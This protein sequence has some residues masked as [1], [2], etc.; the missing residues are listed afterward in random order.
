MLLVPRRCG[1]RDVRTSLQSEDGQ[2]LPLMLAL[3]VLILLAGMVVFW[4][5]FSTSQAATVQTAADAAALA[6]EQSAVTQL[7]TNPTATMQQVQ[8]TACQQASSY[9]QSNGAHVLSCAPRATLSS[10][11]GYD[12]IV[13]AGSNKVLPS[14]S[15][16]SGQAA[17]ATARASTDPFS[18][19]SPAIKTSV[20]YSCDASV[21][22]GPVFSAHGGPDGFFPAAGTDYSYGCEPKLAG[23]LDE[24]AQAKNLHL[25]GTS[26]YVAQTAANVTAPAAVAHG[27]GDASTTPGLGSVPDSV[28][29]KY[30][31]VRPFPAQ[32]D[33]VELSGVSCNQQSGSADTGSGGPIALGNMNVHLVPLGGG[34]VGQLGFL[35]GGGISVGESPLQVGCQIYSVWQGLHDSKG[36]P[37][38]LLLVALMVAQDESDMGQNVGYNRTDPNQSVGVFQQISGDGW[39]SIPEEWDVSTA[40]AMFFEGGHIPGHNSTEGLL[41]YW[42]ADSGEPTW[43]LAQDVQRSG[44]G[45]DSDGAAN[46]GAAANVEAAQTM[47]GQVTSGQCPAA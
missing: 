43:E 45:Q 20:S 39:G 17:T 11:I 27:C 23:A 47:L 29:S 32:R 30:G 24:L 14:G 41:D 15:P 7:T 38:E 44:A 28:L 42:P 35:G 19:A 13:E 4:I 36:I 37:R 18:Q 26:G 40:A 9:A 34:P 33:V 6:A 12:F 5:G 8:S 21:V 3:I 16:D 25:Q 2:I 22:S 1:R 46:Y 10:I 31:L